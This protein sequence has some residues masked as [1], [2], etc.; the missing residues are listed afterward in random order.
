MKR[1]NLYIG[2]DVG[3]S[4]IAVAV[5]TLVDHSPHLT[6]LIS[7]PH[8]G[9]RRGMISDLEETVSTISQVIED[10]ERTS[11]ARL[12][13][14]T[15][16]ITGPQIASS[17]ARGVVAVAKPTGEIETTDA[18]RA[19]EAAKVVAL[20]PNREQLH[21][22]ARHFLVDGAGEIRDPVGMT[23]VRLEVEAL[24]IGGATPAIRNLE[25]AVA[26]AGLNLDGL[27]FAPL[28]SSRLITDK[29][30]RESGVAVVDIGAGGTN[31]AVYEEG[32]VLHAANVPIGSM[33][34]TNDI[35]IGIRTNLD[36]AEVVKIRHGSCL[37]DSTREAEAIN[38]AL[39]DPAEGE[40]VSRRQVAEIIEARVAEICHFIQDEFGK[41]GKDGLLPAG[42]V[43]TGGG[44]GLE[45]IS[46]L[47]R[48]KLRLP[49][50]IGSPTEEING[51]VDKL[52]NPAYATSIGL[53][54]SGIG[55]A[56]TPAGPWRF[57]LG[58][59]GGVISR[60]RGVFK[61]FT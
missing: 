54:L 2:L 50:T 52:D 20:P 29:R 58:V 21:L 8:F 45:G 9:L 59:L 18:N 1:E 17:P 60:F 47:M 11:G 22:F 16:S 34:I 33:H 25:K 35:A 49:C 4:K 12:T 55:S 10:A 40:K 13:H 42:I 15:V 37:P 30:Q 51:L 6:A 53:A 26:Q 56:T 31:L 19:I 48:A 38:L 27:M 3:H 46:E 39:I 24:I 61:N 23:G 43:L 32:E 7:V 5:A 28:A 14:A 36:V 41:I 57:D 44:S